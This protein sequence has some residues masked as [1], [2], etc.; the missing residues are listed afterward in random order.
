MF[1]C[2]QRDNS[3]LTR[4]NTAARAVGKTRGRKQQ[5]YY[6]FR[7]QK[8]KHQIVYV[9]VYCIYTY[10]HGHGGVCI[11]TDIRGAA[12]KRE[13]VKGLCSRRSP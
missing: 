10:I 12:V 9:H 4:T 6:Y 8:K 2:V 7:R 11:Y 1:L 3:S 5:E 13:I